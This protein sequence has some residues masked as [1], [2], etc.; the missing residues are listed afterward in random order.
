[1][2]SLTQRRYHLNRPSRVLAG[3]LTGASAGLV[4]GLVMPR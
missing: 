2:N 1:M 3:A 4:L